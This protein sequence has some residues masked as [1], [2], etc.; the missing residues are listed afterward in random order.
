[1]EE[2][3]GRGRGLLVGQNTAVSWWL[4]GF[5]ALVHKGCCRE[6]EPAGPE[7]PRG[8]TGLFA[9]SLTGEAEQHE[10]RISFMGRCLWLGRESLWIILD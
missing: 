4:R 9:R 1:V 8:R 5:C 2:V 10:R 7:P 3:A 6:R